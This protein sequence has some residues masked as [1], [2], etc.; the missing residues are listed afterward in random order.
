MVRVAIGLHREEEWDAGDREKK[1][2]DGKE[3]ESHGQN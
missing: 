1:W 3:E 2:E